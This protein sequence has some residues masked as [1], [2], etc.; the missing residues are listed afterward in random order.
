VVLLQHAGFSKEAI[1][2]IAACSLVS[3]IA[4]GPLLGLWVDRTPQ[5]LRHRIYA[6]A[7]LVRAGVQLAAWP[8]LLYLPTSSAFW[9]C[10]IAWTLSSAWNTGGLLGEM[11]LDSLGTHAFGKVR[12]WGGIGF[13]VGSLLTGLL[14]EAIPSLGAFIIFPE[15]AVAGILTA[16]AVCRLSRLNQEWEPVGLSLAEGDSGRAEMKQE[17]TDSSESTLVEMRRFL[18]SGDVIFFFMLVW[19]LGVGE[20]V[21]QSYTYVRLELLPYGS[22]TVMGLSAVCMIM[23]EVPFFYYSGPIAARLGTMPI[24]ALALL[25]MFLRQAWIAVLWDA[26][27]VLPGELLHG[28]T[29][30]VANAVIVLHS[31]EIAPENLRNWVQSLQTVIF[32]GA[33]QGLAAWL[34]GFIMRRKGVSF[35]FFSSAWFA[36]L[37]ATPVILKSCWRRGRCSGHS[38]A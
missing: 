4:G 6:M 18:C 19:A 7:V 24:V 8:A 21:M 15:S 13:A 28:V 26:R 2:I 32:T 16:L 38:E 31:R 10:L 20:G 3:P 36:L 5:P 25:C 37:A 30:S 11:C 34:G 14:A 29:Y 1:G 12:L 35:L 27:W 22:T 17:S 9:C 23:S 33:G